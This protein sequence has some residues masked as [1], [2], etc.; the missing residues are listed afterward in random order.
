MAFMYL[1]FPNNELKNTPSRIVYAKK[2]QLF[3]ITSGVSAKI[4]ARHDSPGKPASQFAR[5]PLFG[6]G[7]EAW[8]QRNVCSFFLA[9]VKFRVKE[10]T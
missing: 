9:S 5:T 4:C 6:V 8:V 3:I 7:S 1:S 10:Q 2:G